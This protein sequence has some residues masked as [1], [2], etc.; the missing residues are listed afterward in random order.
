MAH[1][2]ISNEPYNQ[3]RLG[4]DGSS[5]LSWD[6]EDIIDGS[7][8]GSI[9]FPLMDSIFLVPICV[10]YLPELKELELI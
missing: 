3:W 1:G 7:T 2:F 4:T 9:T 10:L 8:T 6:R 5:F